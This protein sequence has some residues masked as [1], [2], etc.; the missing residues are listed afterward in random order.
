MAWNAMNNDWVKSSVCLCAHSV[1]RRVILPFLL[2]APCG[3]EVGVGVRSQTKSARR[4]I[5]RNGERTKS[6]RTNPKNLAANVR[7]MC[8]EML[9]YS[10][11]RLRFTPVLSM[12]LPLQ[13]FQ[14]RYLSRPECVTLP[15]AFYSCLSAARAR[16]AK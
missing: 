6:K 12:T 15:R 3:R 4:V 16:S 1:P 11:R 10:P 7:K 14:S 2:P 8:G 5:L 13:P 9:R